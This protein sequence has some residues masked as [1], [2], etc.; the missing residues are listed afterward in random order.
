M[1]EAMMTT[2]SR[3]LALALLVFPGSVLAHRLEDNLQATLVCIEPAAIRLKIN[4][5][6]GASVSKLMVALIDGDGDGVI[7]KKEAAAYAARMK[8]DL[9]VRLD[10]RE[11]ELKFTASDFPEPA[12]LRSGSEIIRLEF[13]IAPSTLAAGKHRL[14]LENRHLPAVSVFLVN[15][16]KPASDQIR[17]VAQ[18]RD[19]SQ[20]HGEIE[21]SFDP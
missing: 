14:T 10:G 9:I 4:L 17:I 3:L 2:S 7:S 16:A 11:V 5:T 13:A 19:E 21:F 8:R 18:R 20:S 15:A 6:P 12:E 1:V